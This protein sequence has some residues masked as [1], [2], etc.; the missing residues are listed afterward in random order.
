VN[1]VTRWAL[2]S[3]RADR[4]RH[5]IRAAEDPGALC[6]AQTRSELRQIGAVFDWAG[7]VA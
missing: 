7:I 6:D 1:A 5:G 2:D 3:L 4:I